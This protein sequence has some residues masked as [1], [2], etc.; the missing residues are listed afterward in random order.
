[1][2]YRLEAV[3]GLALAGPAILA[4]IHYRFFS[5]AETAKCAWC[6]RV[7]RKTEMIREGSGYYCTSEEAC[8]H[9]AAQQW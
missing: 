6:H 2:G 4:L 3:L 8:D 1:M 7:G 5:Q 9:W